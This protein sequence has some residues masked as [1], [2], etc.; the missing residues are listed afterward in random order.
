M[1]ILNFDCLVLYMW[2][3][4]L[5]CDS[6]SACACFRYTTNNILHLVCVDFLNAVLSICL[7]S[8]LH[9]IKLRFHFVFGSMLS[10]V[11]VSSSFACI[12]MLDVCG[13]CCFSISIYL[14]RFFS[15]R[16]LSTS[17]EWQI[18]RAHTHSHTIIIRLS[19]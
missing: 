18:I 9:S 11:C 6:V 4:V 17:F 7:I 3:A 19:K 10:G 13:K 16:L 8:Y 14:S 5:L 12:E 2:S 15:R 1:M